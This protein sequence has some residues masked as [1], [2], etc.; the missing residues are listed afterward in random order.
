MKP[1][2]NDFGFSLL[3]MEVVKLKPSIDSLSPKTEAA[4][5]AYMAKKKQHENQT[6][7]GLRHVTT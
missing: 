6:T 3:M 5:Q 1:R 7:A 2:T 4:Y